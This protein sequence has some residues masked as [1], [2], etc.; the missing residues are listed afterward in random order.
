MRFSYAKLLLFFH[1]LKQN[2]RQK[3]NREI[4]FHVH[5]LKTGGF[6]FHRLKR[7]LPTVAVCLPLD[8]KDIGIDRK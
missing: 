7:T 8:V 2:I 6:L 4:Q 5:F 3:C 1:F